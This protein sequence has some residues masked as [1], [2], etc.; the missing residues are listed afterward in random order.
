MKRSSRVDE[1]CAAVLEIERVVRIA[2][3]ERA[4]ARGHD[5]CRSQAA[6]VVRDEALRFLGR[7]DEL[8]DPAVAPCKLVEEAPAD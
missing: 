8:A 7:V 1:Q 6:E 3:V 4:S 5:A 2:S